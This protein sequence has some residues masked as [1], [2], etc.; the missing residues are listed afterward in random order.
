MDTLKELVRVRKDVQA[1]SQMG[2]TVP[3]SRPD[4]GDVD[5]DGGEIAYGNNNAHIFARLQGRLIIVRVGS[6][7]RSSDF[8]GGGYWYPIARD[9]LRYN[10]PVS[11]CCGGV[12][13]MREAAAPHVPG[14]LQTQPVQ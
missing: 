11:D 9:V 13:E 12:A 8:S 5:V 7:I 6:Q 1:L 4:L 14:N 2:F 3:G 10:G